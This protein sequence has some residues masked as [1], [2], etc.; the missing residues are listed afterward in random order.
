MVGKCKGKKPLG[1]LRCRW[2]KGTRMKLR[3]IGWG[4]G[5]YSGFSLLRIGADGRLLRI[6]Q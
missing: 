1:R 6:R 2:E 4:G 3:D 5:V